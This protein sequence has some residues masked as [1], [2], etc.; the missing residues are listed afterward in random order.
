MRP[1]PIPAIQSGPVECLEVFRCRTLRF[2][3]WRRIRRAHAQA[4]LVL[5]PGDLRTFGV[6]RALIISRALQE[7]PSGLARVVYIAC[8][9]GC[10]ADLLHSWAGVP[11]VV[12]AFRGAGLA[13]HTREGLDYIAGSAAV[14]ARVAIWGWRRGGGA[15]QALRHTRGAPGIKVTQVAKVGHWSSDVHWRRHWRETVRVGAHHGWADTAACSTPGQDPAGP[16]VGARGVGVG[17]AGVGGGVGCGFGGGVGGT[18]VGV[19]VHDG[20]QASYRMFPTGN[21]VTWSSGAHPF[22]P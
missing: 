11:G 1:L 6:R 14:V 8:G 18:G 2:G 22:C 13:L 12:K 20:E 15:G 5:R 21:F 10:H 7:A 17:D 16:G 3:V 4:G 9:L 19:A